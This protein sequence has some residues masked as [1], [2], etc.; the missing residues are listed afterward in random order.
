MVLQLKILQLSKRTTILLLAILKE[1][2]EPF[3]F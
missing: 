2:D 1:E 3:F